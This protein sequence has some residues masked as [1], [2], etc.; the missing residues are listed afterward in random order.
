MIWLEAA[1]MDVQFDPELMRRH[2]REGPRYTSYPTALQFHERVGIADYEREARNSAGARLCEPLSAYVH[3]PFCFSP[4]FYCGCNRVI[5]REAGRAEPYLRQLEQEIG[6]RSA[7]FDQAR[8]LEQL[9]LGGGT[10]TFLTPALL[11]KLLEVM[12]RHFSLTDADGR[13]YS[14]EIDPRTVSSED[15]HAL[16]ALGFN[17]VSLG[18]QDFDPQVQAAVNRLQP[19]ALV[20]SLLDASRAAGM[21]SINFDLIYG[22]P[23]QSLTS[24]ELTLDQVI[25]MRPDRLAVYGY[26]HL[27]SMF[28]AQRQIRTEDLPD[29]AHRLSLLQLAI[30][31]LTSDGYQYIGLDHFALPEDSLAQAQR[32]G[33][34]HRTF[35]GYTTHASRDLV[36]FGVSAIGQVGSLF[37]QNYKRLQ[38]YGAALA[39]GVLPHQRG[40]IANADDAI[41]RD[42][43]QR[44]MC[45][46]GLEFSAVERAH[47]IEFEDYFAPEL[48]RVQSLAADGL[49]QSA[50]RGFALTPRGRLLMR[51]VAMAFDA[52]LAR[53]DAAQPQSRVI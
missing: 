18:V 4:C 33:T 22:L 41:R 44:I 31:K 30:G 9:H 2:N 10:P 53:R 21:R 48:Q 3:V 37:I 38:D 17:R 5:T 32:Q 39:R 43:I 36:S 42:V 6:L 49:V 45:H 14:I 23:L 47:G 52:Y 11:G 1:K 8:T 46:G 12:G 25:A 50:A 28:K 15:I 19:A 29:A 34:L 26:A 7:Y 27:P 13:D 51:N 16:A 40:V 35:Q 24:F 20:R